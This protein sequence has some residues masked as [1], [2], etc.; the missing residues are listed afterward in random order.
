MP[1][2]YGIVDY[3]EIGDVFQ[4]DLTL[5]YG[6]IRIWHLIVPIKLKYTRL[7]VLDAGDIEKKWPYCMINASFL[8]KFKTIG[9]L[10]VWV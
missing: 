7:A 10:H 6:G 5:V 3:N 8:E 1:L 2:F 9:R 4:S